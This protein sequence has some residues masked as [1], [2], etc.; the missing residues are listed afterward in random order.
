LAGERNALGYCVTAHPLTP[1]LEWAARGGYTSAGSLL[2]KAGGKARVWGQVIT[3][4]RIPTRKTHEGMAFATLEDPTGLCELVFFPKAYRRFGE[5][6]TAGRPLVAEGK[7]ENDR[8]GLTL[9]VEHAWAVRGV[10]VQKPVE[11]RLAAE[12]AA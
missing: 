11:E 7:I 4:K 5:L 12:G 10:V 8:G 3:Y 1:M 9:T 6:I 2:E